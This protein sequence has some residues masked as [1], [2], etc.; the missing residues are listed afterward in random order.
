M[1]LS[2]FSNTNSWQHRGQYVCPWLEV[3][4]MHA[5]TCVYTHTH[6]ICSTAASAQEQMQTF[7]F[8]S[9]PSVLSRMMF[10]GEGSGLVVW[11]KT[12]CKH[13]SIPFRIKHVDE[14]AALHQADKDKR[15]NDC[16][17]VINLPK[18]KPESSHLTVCWEDYY[19]TFPR[20][21]TAY[22]RSTGGS[23]QI[24]KNIPW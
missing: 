12:S 20:Y 17:W 6:S 3:T 10:R 5:H 7:L 13:N 18:I 19:I 4:C 11:L 21:I 16:V 9:W 2:I 15:Q 22:R 1:A 24:I 14:R 8:Y 23:E